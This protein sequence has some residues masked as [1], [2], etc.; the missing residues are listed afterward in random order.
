MTKGGMTVGLVATLRSGAWL[1][2]RRLGA[3]PLLFLALYGAIGLAW[4]LGGEGFVDPRG[5]PLGGDFLGFWAAS[6]VELSRGAAAV[7]DVESLRA[8][9]TAVMGRPVPFFAWLYPPTASLLVWPLA[10]LPYGAAFVLWCGGQLAAAL[11]VLRRILDHPLTTRVALA[12]PATFLCLV[13]GQNALLSTALLGGG[14]SLLASRPALAGAVLAG[15]L[16]KPH[17]G[18]LIPVALLA[19]RQWRAITGG[20]I[21][22]ALYGLATLAVLGPAAWTAF[23]AHAGFAR[24]VLEQ[25][26]VD[27]GK[28]ASPYA[29]LRLLGLGSTPAWIGQGAVTLAA[30][31]LVALQWRRPGPIGIKAAGLAAAGLLASPFLLDYDLTILALSI[32]WLAAEGRAIGFR[33]WEISALALAWVSPLLV[34]VIGLQIHLPVAPL[35]AAMVLALTVRRSRPGTGE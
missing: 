27:W 1:D 24:D 7:Y 4:A 31:A 32:A 26:W 29:G 13:H 9:Q 34:R 12:F 19:G 10:L 5:I 16:Y 33:P 8:A 22:G 2:R 30:A 3:Y 6:K 20:A 23:F 35:V 18:L 14:L 21:A 11:S 15:L 25:G 17:L 28:M